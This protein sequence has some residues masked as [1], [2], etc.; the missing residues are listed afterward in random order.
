MPFPPLP[1]TR[2]ADPASAKVIPVRVVAIS[3][4]EFLGRLEQIADRKMIVQTADSFFF[5]S[6]TCV[7]SDR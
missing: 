2:T 5:L 3:L 4:A 1:Q 7:Q 6:F